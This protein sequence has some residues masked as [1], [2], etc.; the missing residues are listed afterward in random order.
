MSSKETPPENTP[1]TLTRIIGIVDDNRYLFD[2][3]ILV[4][5][6]DS[7]VLEGLIK[8]QDTW[9][10]TSEIQD[11]GGIALGPS[12][13]RERINGIIKGMGELVGT[14]EGLLQTQGQARSKRYR[15]SPDLLFIDVRDDPMYVRF[16]Y[17]VLNE[18]PP[19]VDYRGDERLHFRSRGDRRR[20][21]G[22]LSRQCIERG[23]H[24]FLPDT[25]HNLRQQ[26]RHL[27]DR[28]PQLEPED[29]VESCRQIE[30]GMIAFLQPEQNEST[31]VATSRAVTAYH[32]ILI[33]TIPQVKRLAV[34]QGLR[35][36]GT[37]DDELFQEGCLQAINEVLDL[38]ASDDLTQACQYFYT[39]CDK[40]IR[41][42]MWNAS[43]MRLQD[44]K[45][46]TEKEYDTLRQVAIALDTLTT[47]LKREPSPAE[48]A[49][50]L[51]ITD[52]EA[53]YAM[54]RLEDSSTSLDFWPEPDS[55]LVSYGFYE[56][57][58][59]EINLAYLQDVVETLF[60]SPDLSDNEKIILSLSYGVYSSALCG[61]E[62][63]TR[64]RWENFTY[65][66]SEEDFLAVIRQNA[67]ME[68]IAEVVRYDRTRLANML[69]SSLTKSRV[70]LNE[71]L[72]L[73][74]LA[75]S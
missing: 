16:K 40:A 21:F 9:A 54:L 12:S 49:M 13:F 37:F 57:I 47:S 41:F 61:A 58:D 69:K 24:T 43:R 51:N 60:L 5:E 27:Y 23:E 46:I 20:L 75:L 71:T 15:L 45:T 7:L 3:K 1:D 52:D 48:V 14:S 34:V 35:Y 38:G 66:Y 65:P 30:E 64:M 59:R 72:S 2:G 62:F 73:D 6:P 33:S 17:G 31:R 53:V 39:K 10:S 4:I 18:V 67:S 36:Q 68:S 56:G 11:A 28:M 63:R 8:L 55:L 22:A 32:R 25:Q 29:L 74:D 70:I 42:K 50:H 26:V 19:Y 44:E